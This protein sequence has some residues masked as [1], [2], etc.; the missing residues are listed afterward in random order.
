MNREYRPLIA[1]LFSICWWGTVSAQ[2]KPAESDPAPP[3]RSGSLLPDG[4]Q[5]QESEDIAFPLKPL[6]PRSAAANARNEALAWYMTGRLLDASHRN[7][8][9]KA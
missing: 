3:A 8:P 5:F 6:V 4:F 9:R 7:E 1:G 2:E